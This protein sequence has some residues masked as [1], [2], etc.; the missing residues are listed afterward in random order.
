MH[1]SE[2]GIRLISQE[3]VFTLVGIIDELLQLSEFLL[4]FTLRISILLL[5]SV[6]FDGRWEELGCQLRSTLQRDIGSFQLG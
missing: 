3:I 5:L 4:F 2:I 1:C 6:L